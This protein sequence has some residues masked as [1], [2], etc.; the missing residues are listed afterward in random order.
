[1]TELTDIYKDL[2][3]LRKQLGAAA[4]QYG[5]EETAVYVPAG[6]MDMVHKLVEGFEQLAEDIA[7]LQAAWVTHQPIALSED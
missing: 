2:D 3:K 1:M 4:E 7:A 5:S 6:S